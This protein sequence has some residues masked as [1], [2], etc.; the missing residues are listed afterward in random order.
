MFVDEGIEDV[1]A[2]TPGGG[3]ER[4]DIYETPVVDTGEG[5]D[6]TNGPVLWG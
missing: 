2:S 4:M 5:E 6:G 3:E 1:V